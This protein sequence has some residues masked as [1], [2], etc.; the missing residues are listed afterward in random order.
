MI[1]FAGT[2]RTCSKATFSKEQARPVVDLVDSLDDCAKW[3][4]CGVEL[5]AKFSTAHSAKTFR[6]VGHTIVL[7]GPPATLLLFHTSGYIKTCH[8]IPVGMTCGQANSVPMN[9]LR[10]PP[11][12]KD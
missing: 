10:Q 11:E 12:P 4:S 3:A 5:G 1:L 9:K 6:A 2:E 7:S 8:L